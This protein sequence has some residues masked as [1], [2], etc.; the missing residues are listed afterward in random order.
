M[1]AGGGMGRTKEE[2]LLFAAAAFLCA[3]GIV[4]GALLAGSLGEEQRNLLAADL[5]RFL[6]KLSTEGVPQGASS[7][8][9][10]YWL[11][12][13][14]LLLIVLLGVSVIG[15]P[16][17]AALDFLKGVLVGFAV[18]TLAIQ[19]GGRGVAFSLVAVAPSNLLALP[20]YLAASAAAAA[21]A[22]HLVRFRLMRRQGPLLPAAASLSGTAAA[23][24]LLLA[25][26]AAAE[27]WLSPPLMAWAAQWLVPG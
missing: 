16:L 13:R 4:C 10:V 22:L 1:R 14:W 21:F 15:L 24:A 11:H 18:A 19:H 7:F 5:S 25:A 26:A 9:T 3:A 27:A 17:L 23:A 12:G 8:W 2:R 6:L 20:A